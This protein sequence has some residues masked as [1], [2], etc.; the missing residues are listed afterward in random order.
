[1]QFEEFHSIFLRRNCFTASS[2]I[3]TRRFTAIGWETRDQATIA[4]QAKEP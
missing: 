3:S 1:M 2:R 4:L